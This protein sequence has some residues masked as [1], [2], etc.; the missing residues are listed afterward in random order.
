MTVAALFVET[1]GIYFGL[2]D[3]DPW[4][5]QRDARLYAGPYPVVAHPPC[6]RWSVLAPLIESLYGYRVGDDG[7]CFEAALNAVR[8]YGGVLEHPA[9]SLAWKRFGLPRPRRQGWTLSL[10]DPGM[11]CEVEQAA[12]GHRARKTTW[13]YAVG[14]EPIDLK[15]GSPAVSAQVSGFQGLPAGTPYAMKEAVRVR[16]DPAARTPAA[17]AQILLDVAR[18]ARNE[19]AA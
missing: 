10:F 16:P 11:T 17:F 14:I 9:H 12:Y 7:G 18:T 4:D 15:W 8:T 3:V 13:L 1:G 2:D 5:E 19:V 6:N